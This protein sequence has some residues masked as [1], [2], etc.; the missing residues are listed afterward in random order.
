VQSSRMNRY[1]LLS[2]VIVSLNGIRIGVLMYQHIRVICSA[3]KCLWLFVGDE[4]GCVQKFWV[5]LSWF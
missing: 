1:I 2:W 5:G 3:Y 4:L